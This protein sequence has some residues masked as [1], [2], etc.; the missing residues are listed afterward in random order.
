MKKKLAVILL[1]VLNTLLFSQ[2]VKPN[3][4]SLIIYRPNNIGQ[5]NDIWCWVKLEDFETGQDVT[6]SK[7]KAKFEWVENTIT[8]ERYLNIGTPLT[9]QKDGNLLQPQNKL[10]LES[11]LWPTV[12]RLFRPE[13]IVKLYDYK[14]TYY[15][16]GGMAMHLNLRPGKYRITVYT[17][18]EK[19]NLFE[20]ENEGDWL[21]NEF[22]YNTENPTNVIFVTPTMNENCF[23]NGAWQINWKAP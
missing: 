15:L 8:V 10:K 16:A 6:Y 11:T 23:Y 13:K 5:M 2:E 14:K 12:A 19:T 21:S 18:K 3:P 1:M 22:I 20:C 7:V 9:M 4:W 17:P